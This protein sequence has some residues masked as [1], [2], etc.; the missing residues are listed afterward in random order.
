VEIIKV[1]ILILFF[2]IFSQRFCISTLCFRIFDLLQM[3]LTRNFE[4]VAS[5]RA[6][7]ISA[8]EI[9]RKYPI[10]EAQY[11]VTKYGPNVLLSL[12]IP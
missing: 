11:V 9:N 8:L 6:I 5:H 7:R 12:I 4:E 10:V 1:Y 3:D 2:Y